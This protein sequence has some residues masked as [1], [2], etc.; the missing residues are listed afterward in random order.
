VVFAL[1]I[2]LVCKRSFGVLARKQPHDVQRVGELDF[3]R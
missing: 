3:G 2:S 1:P